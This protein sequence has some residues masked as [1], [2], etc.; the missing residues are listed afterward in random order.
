MVVHPND[1]DPRDECV[2]YLQ[3]ESTGQLENL[4]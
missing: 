2:P 4:H 1:P 3:T